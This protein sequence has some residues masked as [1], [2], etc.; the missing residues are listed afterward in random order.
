MPSSRSSENDWPDVR[1]FL[2]RMALAILVVL[3]VAILGGR[4][5]V[6][7]QL[8][9]TRALLERI[10]DRFAILHL[11]ID[12]NAQDTVIR[13]RVN[14]VRPIAL[15]AHVSRP[16]PQGWLEVTTTVGTMLQPLVLALAIATAWPSTWRARMRAGAL[17]LVLSL[18]F[19]AVDVPMTLHAYV[20]DMLVFHF[21]P[22]RF[23]PLMAVHG[24]LTGGGRLALG[25]V[26]G[27]LAVFFATC[28]GA[29]E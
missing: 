24:F 7:A 15:G 16:H 25:A 1:Q 20:W 5:L 22:Q 12:R 10:D 3:V 18:T 29:R 14:P 13:L 9:V 27:A 2:P 28:G 6:E 17:A 19:L 21:D 11:G 26:F 23:S 4:A 8:P